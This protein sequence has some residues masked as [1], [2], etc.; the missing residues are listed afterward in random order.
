MITDWPAVLSY[1]FAYTFI[2]IVCAEFHRMTS[3]Q[4]EYYFGPG[5]HA[6]ALFLWPIW[7]LLGTIIGAVFIYNFIFFHKSDSTKD[8]ES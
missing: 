2:G 3:K 4:G 5:D 1:F 8:E 6:F 7:M